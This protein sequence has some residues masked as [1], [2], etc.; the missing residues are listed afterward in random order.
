MKGDSYQN[1]KFLPEDQSFFP[2]MMFPMLVYYKVRDTKQ[3]I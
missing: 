1:F 2:P 3:Q